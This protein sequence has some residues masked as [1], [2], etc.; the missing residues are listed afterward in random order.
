M[1]GG[2]KVVKQMLLQT[3]SLTVLS[4]ITFVIIPSRPE[5]LNSLPNILH[6]TPITGQKVDQTSFI[7]INLLLSLAY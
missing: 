6:F 4:R 3:C 2:K 7:T 5:Q 1:A